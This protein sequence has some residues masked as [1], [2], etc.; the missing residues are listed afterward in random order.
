MPLKPAQLNSQSNQDEENP[1]HQGFEQKENKQSIT[2]KTNNSQKQNLKEKVPGYFNQGLNYIF[3]MLFVNYFKITMRLSKIMKTTK[4]TFYDIPS[5]QEKEKVECNSIQLQK[6]LQEIYEKRQPLNAY[7]MTQIIFTVFSID[8]IRCITFH[9]FDTFLRLFSSIC[10]QKLIESVQIDD[11]DESTKWV[12]ILSVYMFLSV[13]TG[14]NSWKE[15]QDLSA[16]LRLSLVTIFLV[17][18]LALDFSAYILVDRHG[19]MDLLII[20]LKILCLPIQ[21]LISKKAANYIPDKNKYSDYRIKLTREIIEG[22]HFVKMYAWEKAFIKFIKTIRSQE[23]ICLLKQVTYNYIAQSLSYGSVLI[24]TTVPFVLIHYFGE[25]SQLNTP[26]IFSTMQNG[27]NYAIVGQV[28]SGKSTLLLTCLKELPSYRGRFNISGTARITLARALYSKS[29]IYLLDDLISAIDSKVA[30]FL[31]QNFFNDILKN[32]LVLLVTHQISKIKNFQNILTIQKGEIVAYGDQE[33]VQKELNFLQAD[34]SLD[35]ENKEQDQ[36]KNDNQNETLDQMEQ[37]K[38]QNLIDLRNKFQSNSNTQKPEVY[39]LNEIILTG[40]NRV[41]GQ[42]DSSD[43][44]SKR[45]L[46]IILGVL[47]FFFCATLI[48]KYV[49]L[50]REIIVTNSSVHSKM[51]EQLIHAPTVYFDKTSGGEILNRFSNDIFYD[52]LFYTKTKRMID[53]IEGTVNFLNL[54][55]TICFIQPY[56]AIVSIVELIILYKWFSINQKINMQSKYFDLLNKTPVFP[57]FSQTLQGMEIV[58]VYG[59]QQ[60]FYD[61]FCFFTNQSIRT[62]MMFWDGSRIF[63]MYTQFATTFSSIIGIIVLTS[64]SDSSTN[65]GL[66]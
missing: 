60:N 52:N 30:K 51:A 18:S 28:G 3:V 48:I 27:Q 49:N 39:I 4:Y 15:G 53:A 14:Q 5:L 57:F 19:S 21:N 36:Q 26:K 8:F 1:M 55:I 33:K 47:C 41:L 22:I 38:K 44:I 6:K 61:K 25:S 13:V 11:Q 45:N 63:G 7:N 65:S 54:M 43:I 31:V 42:Y 46:F 35:E 23:M 50:G 32:N 24:S 40:Y 56:F 29:D 37:T 2:K 9:I 12:I 66:F 20:G 59:Q 34:A 10:L 64:L 62:N 16:K 58:Q 17:S